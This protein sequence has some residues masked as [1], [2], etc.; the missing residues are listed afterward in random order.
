MTERPPDDDA[1]SGDSG[2]SGNGEGSDESSDDALD[3]PGSDPHQRG[4]PDQ[5]WSRDYGADVPRTAGGALPLRIIIIV[6]LIFAAGFYLFRRWRQQYV[7]YGVDS[8]GE[9]SAVLA[10]FG[11]S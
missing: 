5:R 10:A 1:R 4:S 8:S 3:R 7:T 2:H 9:V 6:I 11:L